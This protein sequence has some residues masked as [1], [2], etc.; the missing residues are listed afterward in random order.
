MNREQLKLVETHLKD[1]LDI[2][3]V[4]HEYTTNDLNTNKLLDQVKETVFAIITSRNS[5]TSS[6]LNDKYYMR[7]EDYNGNPKEKL[8]MKRILKDNDIYNYLIEYYKKRISFSISHEIRYSFRSDEL[9]YC[10]KKPSSVKK[11]KFSGYLA[12]N[13]GKWYLA[14]NLGKLFKEV[15]YYYDLIR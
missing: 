7:H 2:L 11:Q 14:N 12:N 4:R 15:I 3:E 5:L 1:S 8:V 10:N 6:S 13:L 9:M